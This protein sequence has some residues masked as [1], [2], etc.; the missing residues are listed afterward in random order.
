MR[1]CDAARVSGAAIPA[2]KSSDTT[3]LAKV[4]NGRT[5]V[6]QT[7][8]RD[9]VWLVQTPQVFRREVLLEAFAHA[10]ATGFIGTDCASA[11]EQLRDEHGASR[12]EIALVEGETRNFKV[13][14]AA[15]L[16]RAARL[17]EV[18]D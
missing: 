18:S 8:A 13:T 1:V 3:K 9:A 16:E 15:D 12:Y 14:F 5:V 17:L 10:R 4:S 6:A 7:L 11:V 2:L